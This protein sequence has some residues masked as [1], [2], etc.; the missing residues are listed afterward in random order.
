MSVSKNF[1]VTLGEKTYLC[2]FEIAKIV[3]ESVEDILTDTLY[4]CTDLICRRIV[5]CTEGTK[6]DEKTQDR[7]T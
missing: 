2:Y 4:K 7:Y 3:E 5:D 6:T 1:R